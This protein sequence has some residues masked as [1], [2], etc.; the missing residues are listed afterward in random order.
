LG[1]DIDPKETY[2]WGWQELHD[3]ETDMAK[4]AARIKPGASVAEV[5]DLLKTDP[6]R[7]VNGVEAYREWLQSLHDEVIS[8]LDGVHFEVPEQVRRIEVMILPLWGFASIH[9][10][11]EDFNRPTHL[12]PTARRP[13]SEG[14]K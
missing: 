14:T 4:T 12:R 7:Q 8:D 11:L 6:Q 3:I 1:Q 5:F 13:A 9:A 10:A 2:D